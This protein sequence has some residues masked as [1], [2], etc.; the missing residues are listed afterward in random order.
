MSLSRNLHRVK[1]H[2]RNAEFSKDL[3]DRDFHMAKAQVAAKMGLMEETS[4]Q[5]NALETRNLLS[6][7]LADP[8]AVNL[9]DTQYD[10]ISASIVQRL[11]L[12]LTD[13]A[14]E[15]INMLRDI[16]EGRGQWQK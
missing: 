2:L 15:E 13:R 8:E 16:V 1:G 6:L 12:M 14:T 4:R 5:T 3:D 7:Y 11:T 9:S 10:A